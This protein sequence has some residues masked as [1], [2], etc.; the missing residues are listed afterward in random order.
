MATENSTD[1]RY[2]QI[3]QAALDDL[4]QQLSRANFETWLRS[5]TLIDLDSEQATIAAPNTFAVEQLRSKFDREVADA[6]STLVNRPV[7]VEFVVRAALDK[8]RDRSA[9]R[10]PRNPAPAVD[11]RSPQPKTQQMELTASAEHGLNPNYTFETFVVGASNRLAH[12]AAMAV[13]DQP[14]RQFNPLFFYGGVGLGKTHL[15]HA[16]GHKAMEEHEGLRVLYVSSERF[17]NDL[18]K[19]IMGQKTEDFRSR[20]RSID[21][22]MIDDI[23]FI[24]GKES[25]QEEFFHTFNELYQSGKQ[26]IISSDRHPKTI[27]TLDDRLR[28]RFEGGLIADVSLPDIETRTAILRRKGEMLGVDAPSDVL[29]YIARRVQSNIRELEGALNKI[30]ALAQLFNQPIRMDIAIQALADSELEARRAE[31]SSDKVLD[32]VTAHFKVKLTDLRGR[33]RRKEIV[34]PRQVAMYLIREETGA[35]LVEIGRELGGRDHTTI[36]HG[37][38]KIEEAVERDTTLRRHITTIRETLYEE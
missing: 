31:I 1:A 30:I 36:M 19:S 32:A 24:A 35:S 25:T 34:L 29:E 11:V 38:S 26:I 23:Q 12:A 28:S 21:I 13:A 7:Q 27:Q 16:I 6:L 18:I 17:T 14:S 37:I 15:L 20:Y 2:D 4:Q 9:R 33:G 10:R 5:T 3:W 8:K 22:L